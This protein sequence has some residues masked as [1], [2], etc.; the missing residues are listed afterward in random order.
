MATSLGQSSCFRPCLKAHRRESITA[1]QQ[2]AVRRAQLTF[3][4]AITRDKRRAVPTHKLPRRLHRLR[5][6]AHTSPRACADCAAAPL[7][8]PRRGRRLAWPASS[9]S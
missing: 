5:P 7:P 2:A 6:S 9:T 3:E 4:I 1:A 8:D